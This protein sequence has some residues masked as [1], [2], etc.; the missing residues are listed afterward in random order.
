VSYGVIPLSYQ[1]RALAD[2]D[3]DW[4]KD[5]VWFQPSTGQVVIWN[6]HPGGGFTGW[7]P[8]NVGPGSGWDIYKVG[9]YDGDGREDLFWR[10]TDGT[11]AVWYMNG[12][13][14]A[15]VQFLEG[16]PLAEWSMPAIGDY[17]GDGR[18]DVLWLSS[19]GTV[20]RWRMQGR[21]VDKIVEPVVGVGG[22]WA[23]VQ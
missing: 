13:N 7:F 4:I 11:T 17:D 14:I 1:V 2:V 8:A 9:D 12:P 3:G 23:S 15:S 22:G 5:I 16:V 19:A 18:E 10:R 21:F 20:I 6:M